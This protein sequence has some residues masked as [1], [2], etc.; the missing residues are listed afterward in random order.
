[1]SASIRID[2]D[3]PSSGEPHIPREYDREE[4]NRRIGLIIHSSGSTGLPKPVML[5][6]KALITHP[7]QGSG[8]HNFNALPW[9]HL[10]GISTSLQAMWMRKTAYLYNTSLPLTADSLVPVIEMVRLEAVHVVPYTLGLIAEKDRGVE[11]LKTCKVVTAT[12]TWTPD[13]LGDRLIRA[14]INLGVVFQLSL[15]L[16]VFWQKLTEKQ[17]RGR[18]GWPCH[19]NGK[20]RRFVEIYP[21]LRQH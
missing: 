21:P 13:E 6:H 9:Y 16:L 4:E 7:T 15:P 19:T 1:M 20:W 17:H 11:A 14:G 8:R 3:R 12:G 18:P 2:Y 5:S 10:Y